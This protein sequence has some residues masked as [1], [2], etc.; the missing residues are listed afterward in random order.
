MGVWHWRTDSLDIQQQM[1]VV[2]WPITFTAGVSVCI[3]SV[4]PGGVV[5]VLFGQFFSPMLAIS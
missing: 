3:S 2:A 5:V 4:G 1:V